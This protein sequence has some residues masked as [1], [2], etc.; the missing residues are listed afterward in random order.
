[1]KTPVPLLCLTLLSV[2]GLLATS[3]FAA[4]PPAVTPA[5]TEV[6]PGVWKTTVGQADSLTLLSAA[7]GSPSRAALAKLPKAPFPI[8]PAEIE[9]RNF[10]AK[11]T[12]RFPLAGNEDIYGLGV[13]FSSM[14]RNGAVFELHVDHWDS[15]KAI[16]GRTHAPVPLYI[17]TKGFAVLFDTA[18]YLKVTV[19]HGVRVAAKDKPP[20]ID[21]TT[22]KIMPTVPG[23][24][25]VEAKW[26]ANPRSDS[27]EVMANAAGMDVYVFA[28]P[29]P[30][31]AVRR[32]NLF[33]GGGALPPKWGLGFLNRV[34]TQYTAA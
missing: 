34:R 27:I 28:G 18:R 25:P 8:D 33:S 12:V 23:A 26:Q 7:G 21:R 3:A 32:Y 15:K 1:M 30:L 10:N 17:S 19:G 6:A 2:S 4:I 14:R 20:V 9:G 22:G 5:W 11:T 29:S 24:A 13:D 31:D 16:T